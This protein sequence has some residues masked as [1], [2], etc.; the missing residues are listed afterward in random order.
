MPLCLL[1]WAIFA[2]K[3]CYEGIALFLSTAIFML[4]I[5]WSYASGSCREAA[6]LDCPGTRRGKAMARRE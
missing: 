6:E 2:P 4:V 1:R 5:I 3:F